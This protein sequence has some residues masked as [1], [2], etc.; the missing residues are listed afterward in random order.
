MPWKTPLLSSRF[1]IG[2]VVW[3]A[4]M[5]IYGEKVKKS[6]CGFFQKEAKKARQDIPAGPGYMLTAR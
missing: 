5:H 4:I 6:L 2:M 3:C 1:R